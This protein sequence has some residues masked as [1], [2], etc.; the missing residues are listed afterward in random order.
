MWKERQTEKYEKLWVIKYLIRSITNRLHNNKFHNT[1]DY[2]IKLESS[3]I[4]MMVYL[5]KKKRFFN[6]IIVVGSFFI[7]QCLCKLAASNAE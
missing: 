5:W 4:Q 2:I 6:I 3:Q 7:D 1:D